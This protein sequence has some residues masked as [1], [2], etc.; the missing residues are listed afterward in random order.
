MTAIGFCGGSHCAPGHDT[1]LAAAGATSVIADL[2]DLG[3]PL[4]LVHP[5]PR[6]WGCC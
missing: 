1:R 5:E 2:R 3:A 6:D 4:V